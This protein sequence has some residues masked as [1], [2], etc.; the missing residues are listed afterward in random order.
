MS[1]SVLRSILLVYL[2]RWGLYVLPACTSGGLPP[3][4]TSMTDTLLSV[5]RVRWEG[6][7]ILQRTYKID[8]PSVATVIS[9]PS[10]SSCKLY[11][12]RYV[13]RSV[14]GKERRAVKLITA[15]KFR[16]WGCMQAI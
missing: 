2:A 12:E 15:G 7:A 9:K 6:S 1:C 8:G 13:T 4:V 5:E 11:T 3:S 14:L 10:R 16:K